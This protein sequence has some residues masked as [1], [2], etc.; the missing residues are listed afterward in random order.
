MSTQPLIAELDQESIATR[1]VLERLP[2]DKWDWKPHEKS[3]KLGVLAVHV[4]EIPGWISLMLNSGEL[5]FATYKYQ[6]Y[7]AKD[8][9]DLVSYFEETLQ[10]A[11][12]D[13][14]KANEED[15]MQNWTM[16]HGDKIFF[17]LPKAVV[18]RTWAMNHLVHHRAQL[19]VYL[20]LL[21][22]PVPGIYG[23]S[24]DEM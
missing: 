7:Q 20:R 16:R 6:P 3:M 24:A 8:I 10:K 9:A 19:G 21:N 17:T 2:Y 12:E 18:I 22:I 15:M 4:A 14:G 1:K 23:P 13:L 5:D 11:K